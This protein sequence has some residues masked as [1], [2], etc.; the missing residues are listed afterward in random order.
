MKKNKLIFGICA[1]TLFVSIVYA[2]NFGFNFDFNSSK[3]N[4][5]KKNNI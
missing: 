3:L 1:F 5:T 4:N 2:L